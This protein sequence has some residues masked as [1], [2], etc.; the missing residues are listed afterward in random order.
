LCQQKSTINFYDALNAGSIVLVN[1]SRSHLKTESRRLFGVL[2]FS[3]IHQS[4]IARDDLPEKRRT[5]TSIYIDEASEIYHADFF[6]SLLEGGRKYKAAMNLFHQSLS[7]LEPDDVDI[8]LNNCATLVCFSVGRLDAER[9]AKETFSFSGKEIKYQDG[10]LLLGKKGK[11]TFY[12][13]QEEMENSIKELMTQRVGECFIRM[14]NEDSAPY[15]ATTI[16]V[17][18]PET[19]IE[20]EEKLREASAKKYNRPLETIFKDIEN[21][22]NR[23]MALNKIEEP[24]TYRE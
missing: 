2:L 17:E 10:D 1:L 21:M 22:E 11:P 14:K 15:I 18:Y 3:K 20:L 23:V 19:S 9:M 13:V 8:I 5:P 12:T 4:I 24:E 6:L 16:K 7:Q